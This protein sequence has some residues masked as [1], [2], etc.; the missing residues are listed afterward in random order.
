METGRTVLLHPAAFR[1]PWHVAFAR[2][3]IE[4]SSHLALTLAV[5]AAGAIAVG[6]VLLLVLVSAPLGG[7]LVAWILWRSAQDGAHEARRL[8]RSA[9]ARARKLGLRVVRGA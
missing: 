4:V 1:V 6:L 9:R 3:A 5:V 8:A 2:A 7:A